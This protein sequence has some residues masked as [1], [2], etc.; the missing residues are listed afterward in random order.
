MRKR[1]IFIYI[2]VI[3]FLLQTDIVYGYESYKVG[4]KV[5]YNGDDYYVIKSSNK[6]SSFITLMR[7]EPLKYSEIDDKYFN[8]A[9]DDFLFL[10]FSSDDIYCMNEGNRSSCTYSY[11]ET[12]IKTY[13]DN[14]AISKIGNNN[15]VE[16]D[17]YKARLMNLSDLL[18]LDYG[19]YD[20]CDREIRYCHYNDNGNY[21]FKKSGVSCNN[22]KC[23]FYY[24]IEDSNT[25]TTHSYRS[26]LTRSYTDNKDDAVQYL[27]DMQDS[28]GCDLNLCDQSGNDIG[29]VV[30]DYLDIN[31]HHVCVQSSKNTLTLKPSYV[32]EW[33][34]YEN[35]SFWTMET[36]KYLNDLYLYSFSSK[37]NQFISSYNTF[38]KYAIRPVIN[39]KKEN[40]DDIYYVGEKI[41]FGEGNDRDDYYVLEESDPGQEYVTVL[42]YTPLRES[43]VGRKKSKDNYAKIPYS[44]SSNGCDSI[45]NTSSCVANF[46]VSLVKKVLD[47]W[48]SN[49]FN[50]NQLVEEDGYEYRLLTIDELK[51]DFGYIERVASVSNLQASE[52]TPSWIY[53]SSIYYWAMPEKDESEPGTAGYGGYMPR[54]VTEFVLNSF[55]LDRGQIRPVINLSKC[56]LN[57]PQC[58]D[59][60]DGIATYKDVIYYSEYNIGDIIKYNN[61]DYYVINTS[62][63]NE[64]YVTVIKA[65]ALT[66]DELYKYGRDKNGHL[67]ANEYLLNNDD[68]E[69]V[70][71]EFTDG[72]GG[73]AYYTSETCRAAVSWNSSSFSVSDIISDG[74]END[75]DK[76]DIKKVLSNWT[77]DIFASDDLIDV[78]GYKFRLLNEDDFKALGFIKNS[79]NSWKIV[80]LDKIAEPFKNEVPRYWTMV[81]GD[82][83]LYANN[84]YRS[85]TIHSSQDELL[86][87]NAVRPVVNINK[88]AIDGGCTKE[89][90]LASCDSIP[91]SE[92]QV[93]D[94][95]STLSTISKWIILVSIVLLVG[96]IV[97]VVVNYKKSFKDK[98]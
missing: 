11:D 12:N 34:N 49:N 69:K 35:M 14:W 21:S 57:D 19:S 44:E 36:N 55:V 54:R 89:K 96:G 26:C 6:K 38:Y 24:N 61:E 88:C 47:E 91:N 64:N 77:N 8:Q 63:E 84:V 72:S 56:A 48:I 45:T 67:F 30:S 15:L 79:D 32:Y 62:S 87:K 85:G 27:A 42:K 60:P 28:A 5:N 53:D 82:D 20:D 98:K 4:D 51:N 3:I 80:D 59:C 94:V 76:S 86:K 66:K 58:V 74:C 92:K 83:K 43:D 7:D 9:T 97:I 22:G 39:L 73:M 29:K 93:V 25:N 18:N 13:V 46:G 95:P 37:N 81:T 65:K 75:F 70:I 40:I 1:I 68:P 23:Y 33:L 41:T 31:I 90:V 10:P 16:V 71:H 50:K 78:D 52:D 17:G 2:L